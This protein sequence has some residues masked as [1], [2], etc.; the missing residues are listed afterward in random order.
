MFCSLLRGEAPTEWVWRGPAASAL[1]PLRRNWLAPGYTLVI[2]NEHAVGVQD[3]SLNGLYEVAL[4]VQRIAQQMATTMGALGVNVLNA[5]GQNSDQ[6]V[7]HLD[8]HVVPRWTDDGLDT[9]IH[10][11]SSHE[12]A[13]GWLDEFRDKLASDTSGRN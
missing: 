12:L 9:W 10:G 5:S 13:E 11:R 7:E 4:L 2:S 1:L 3:V 6:S 8:F